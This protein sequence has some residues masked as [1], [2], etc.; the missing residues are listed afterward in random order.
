ML[1]VVDNQVRS[2]RKRQVIEGFESKQ[3]TGMYVGIRSHTN[4]YPVTDVIPAD[5]DVT[6]RLA[7][8][9]TRLDSIAENEQKGLINWGYAI[10]DTGLRAHVEECRKRPRGTLPYDDTP[11]VSG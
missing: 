9:P 5:P 3:R 2:L 1:A 8:I 4:D 10:C 7:A 6:R 11:L